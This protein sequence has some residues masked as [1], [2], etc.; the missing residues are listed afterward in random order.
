MEK[1]RDCL[2]RIFKDFCETTKTR[3]SKFMQIKELSVGESLQLTDKIQPDFV[4]V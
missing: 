4:Y 2:E 3:L 1:K